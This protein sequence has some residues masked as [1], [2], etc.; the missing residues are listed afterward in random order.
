MVRP[1]AEQAS[2]DVQLLQQIVHGDETALSALLVQYAQ[3]LRDFAYLTVRDADLAADVVQEIF[4]SLW[5]RRETLS[6]Q[7]SVADYLYRA[8]RN[9]ALTVIKHEAAQQRLRATLGHQFVIDP[10][11]AMTTADAGLVTR[12]FADAVEAAIQSLTPRVR[13]AFLLRQVQGMAYE[14][15]AAALDLSVATVQSQVSRAIRQ[16]SEYLRPFR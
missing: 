6:I 9:R 1:S 5:Q 12:E 10:A 7:G 14:Q 8:V 13:E 4:V 2:R 11:A 3:P 15:I 16:I